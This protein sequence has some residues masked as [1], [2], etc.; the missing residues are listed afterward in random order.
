[1][2]IFISIL[3]LKIYVKFYRLLPKHHRF[4]FKGVSFLK[5]RENSLTRFQSSQLTDGS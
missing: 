3:I 4:S 2:Y 1:M 5:L